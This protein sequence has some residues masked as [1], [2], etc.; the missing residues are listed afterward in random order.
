MAS[1]LSILSVVFLLI[2]N[3]ALAQVPDSLLTAHAFKRLS[4]Q[5][6]L[7]FEVVSVSKHPEKLSNAASAIQ[8]I[9]RKDIR[10]SCA[11]T[12]PEA[13]RLANNLQVA[14]VNSSQ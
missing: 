3:L 14:Q 8:V 2:S 7:E 12:L 10:N 9:T 6:L 4:L 1:H 11:K 5:E 13:L